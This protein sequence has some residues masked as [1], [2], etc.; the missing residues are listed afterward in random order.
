MFEYRKGLIIVLLLI[1]LGGILLLGIGITGK[2]V[3]NSQ[4]I[5]DVCKENKDCE[6]SKVCC[7]FYEQE[8]GIC[9]SPEMCE[10]VTKI[11]REEKNIIEA[12]MSFT[13]ETPKKDNTYSFEIILGILILSIVA[14]SLYIFYKD[15]NKEIRKKRRKK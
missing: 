8:S 3:M 2:A 11:T 10:T 15:K 13:K 4:T 1:G 7:L 12:S 5:S 14:I 6:N 9:Y